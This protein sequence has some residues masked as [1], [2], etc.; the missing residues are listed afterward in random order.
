MMK[1]A[2]TLN[3]DIAG[4]INSQT[5]HI[6]TRMTGFL[7]ETKLNEMHNM[8]LYVIGNLN[9]NNM[10]SFEYSDP[11]CIIA[12]SQHNAIEMYN[13]A[14]KVE[15]GSFLVEVERDLKKVKVEPID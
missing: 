11:Y 4:F 7:D 12:R 1:F 15:T 5:S 13:E 3:K 14:L 10:D 6:G 8:S 9:G 2:Y